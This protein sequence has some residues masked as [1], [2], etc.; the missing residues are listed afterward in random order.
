M[1]TEKKLVSGFS[2]LWET[3]MPMGEAAVRR[4]NLIKN[5]DD[6]RIASVVQPDRRAIVNEVG[7]RLL[8]KSIVDE[9]LI[10]LDYDDCVDSVCLV[11]ME[12]MRYLKGN[13][14]T[15]VPLDTV[16]KGEAVEI[17]KRLFWSLHYRERDK[18]FVAFPSFKGCGVLRN[19]VGDVQAD[20]TLY[21]VK[22]GDRMFRQGDI[23]QLIIY[24]ALNYASHENVI[25][26]VGL[27]NPRRGFFC[28][29]NLNELV[30]SISGK[31]APIMFSELIE[32]LSR[33]N[34]SR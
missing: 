28:K 18:P 10:D 24:C 17:A 31:T 15:I 6:E 13:E 26:N 21:E 32:F 27:I 4:I 2:S 34:N 12:Y 33:D 7:F 11:V 29:I 25:N 1:I 22:S 19:C 14:D 23:R 9:R 16:E 30:Y 5:K 3:L 20:D 8:C